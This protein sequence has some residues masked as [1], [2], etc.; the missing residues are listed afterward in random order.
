MAETLKALEASR[1]GD[2]DKMRLGLCPTRTSR[3]LNA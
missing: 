2:P 3:N 1:E